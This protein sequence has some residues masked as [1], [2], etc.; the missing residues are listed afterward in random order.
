MGYLDDGMSGDTGGQKRFLSMFMD[1]NDVVWLIN[2]PAM[3]DRIFPHVYGAKVQRDV[4]RALTWLVAFQAKYK[5][6]A[7]AEKLNELVE[8]AN[9][10]SRPVARARIKRAIDLG[11]LSQ[12]S[13]GKNVFYFLNG[14]QMRKARQ[15]IALLRVLDKVIE[16]QDENPHDPLAGS[17][18][19]PRDVYYNVL[20]NF[21]KH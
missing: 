5:A 21:S 12:E 11:L 19:L 10:C 3:E 15:V 1:R 2:R 18:L 14:P 16:K 9:D 4:R 17:E 7:P 20:D 13:D 6:H 8:I